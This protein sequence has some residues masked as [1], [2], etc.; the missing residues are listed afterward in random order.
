ALAL[1]LPALLLIALPPRWRW[2]SLAILALLAITLGSLLASHW[3]TVRAWE[4]GSDLASDPALSLD[5]FEGRLELWS[6]AIY[7]IQDFPFT[8]MGMNT[9]RKVVSALYPLFTISPESD[10]AHAHNEFLQAALDLGIPGLVAFLA[11]YIGAFWM[12]VNIWRNV[13]TFNLQRATVLGLGGGML[14]HL[15][16]GLTD[17]VALG[18]KPGVLFWML[19][20]LIA[21]LHG[22]AQEHWTAGGGSVPALGVEKWMMRNAGNR[23]LRCR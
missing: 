10:I 12:L 6:R 13:P 7:G 18:A 17:A 19:L 15:L 3:E 1:T 5:T 2:Y 21:G 9:F 8:G 14:A 11:L 16:Y 23:N 22:Q 20:G 4:T